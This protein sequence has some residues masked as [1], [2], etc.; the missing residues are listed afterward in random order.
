MR[1]IPGFER[2]HRGPG[3]AGLSSLSP[4]S[5]SHARRRAVSRRAM[6]GRADIMTW[7]LDAEPTSATSG[8]ELEDYT[9]SLFKFIY[10]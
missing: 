1:R 9:P 6:K 10:Y 5:A 8:R 2:A 4:G 3:A 7:A